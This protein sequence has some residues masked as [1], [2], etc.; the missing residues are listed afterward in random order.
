MSPLS[1]I[2]KDPFTSGSSGLVPASGG[3]TTKFLRADATF[4]VPPPTDAFPIGSVFIAVVATN[5]GTLLGYGT[6]SA[7]A[8]GRFLVG[9]N[10]ADTDFDVV[11]ETGGAKTHTLATAN[12]PSHTHDITDPTHTHAISDPG[13]VHTQRIK[14]T[15][16]AG[17][18][19]VQGANVAN[20]ASNGTT[21][22][23][24]TGITV[25]D[26][27]TGITVTDATGSGTAVNHVPPYIVVYMW[28]R[29][30]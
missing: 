16:T 15:G 19:G 6:W 3:G 4:Q 25:S 30:A 23:T 2:I 17:A 8:T 22:S 27:I 26:S 12:L 24:T 21:T 20:D 10:G 28:K 14:N 1:P 29:T 18:T 9:I 7:F 11:E 13:H 5:P